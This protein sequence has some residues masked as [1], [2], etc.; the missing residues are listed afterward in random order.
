MVSREPNI[1]S[2]N[3]VLLDEILVKA[4]DLLAFQKSP[5][6]DY[7]SVRNSVWN[8]KSIVGKEKVFIEHKED[9]ITLRSGFESS[10]NFRILQ[11]LELL[12]NYTLW[13]SLI[14][15]DRPMSRMSDPPDAFSTW[16]NT[17]FGE[18]LRTIEWPFP[19]ESRAKEMAKLVLMADQAK[20]LLEGSARYDP[21][22]TAKK[23]LQ[24]NFKVIQKMLRVL[25]SSASPVLDLVEVLPLKIISASALI[26]KVPALPTG[27]K[28]SQIRLQEQSMI[29]VGPS[30]LICR[31]YP[32]GHK[33]PSASSSSSQ[34]SF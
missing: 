26:L 18:E 7:S 17:V 15:D 22:K 33:S 3:T 24:S 13:K 12:P 10:Y 27:T 14:L 34:F 5:K 6:R 1:H 32:A 9:V 8:L 2:T 28:T 16:F 20:T 30:A 4:R 31:Q 21:S 25:S 11:N 29:W 23:W 19:A